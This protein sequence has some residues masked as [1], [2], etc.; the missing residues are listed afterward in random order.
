MAKV[1]KKR[2]ARK[3]AISKA[4]SMRDRL[5]KRPQHTIKVPIDKQNPDI[6]DV[7]LQI[8]GHTVQIQRG[9]EIKVSD[10][11]KRLL[12]RGGYL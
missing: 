2:I 3:S 4:G 11:E 7:T 8:N 5:N 9:V 6:L 12:E 1:S 10:I